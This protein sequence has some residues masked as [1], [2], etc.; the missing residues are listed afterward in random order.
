MKNSSTSRKILR[1][2]TVSTVSIA[3][4]LFILGSIGYAMHNIFRSAEGVREGVVMLVELKDGLSESERD[5]LSSAIAA[6]SIVANIAFVSKE[7]KLADEQFRRAFDVDIKEV[8]GTNP[9]PDS[10]D[11]TLS[12]AAADSLALATFV[13]KTRAMAEVTNISYPQS[14]LEQVHSVL[15]TMQLLLILFGGAMVVISV[16]LLN[17]TLRLTIY[18]RREA[19][20]TMK[21]V[22]A[23]RWFIIKPFLSRSALQG[24]VAGIFATLLFVGALFGLDHTLP[25]LALL[26][27]VEIVAITTAAMVIAGVV[28]SVLFTLF[29][30][31]KFVNMRS[32]NIHLY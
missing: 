26:E 22:G 30:V 31:N 32:N 9:L 15:D 18:S 7:D 1:S 29:A 17:N 16:V 10:F 3:L 2:Y 19:I 28:V 4:V 6:D 13:D 14:T 24:L 8:L 20:N 23:T 5:S 11:V 25:Q 27:Q 12:A 21:L